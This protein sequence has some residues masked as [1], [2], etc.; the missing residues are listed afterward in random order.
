MGPGGGIVIGE[1]VGDEKL[2]FVCVGTEVAG[3]IEGPGGEAAEPGVAVEDRVDGS[4]DATEMEDDAVAVV[5]GGEEE[6][7]SHLNRTGVRAEAVFEPGAE[8][9]RTGFELVSD[10]G[11]ENAAERTALDAERGGAGRRVRGVRE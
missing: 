4:A 9:D 11:G 10:R 2:K 8:A 3:Q 7:F 5:A 1:G 6:L